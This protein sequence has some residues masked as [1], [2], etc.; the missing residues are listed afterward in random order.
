MSLS[1]IQKESR[2]S[3]ILALWTKVSS[4]TTLDDI[5]HAACRTAIELMQADRSTFVFFDE[6]LATG[7]IL[8]EHSRESMAHQLDSFKDDTVIP[9]ADVPEERRLLEEFKPIKVL[10]VR[11]LN[12]GIFK[13]NLVKRSVKSVLIMPVFSAKRLWGSFSLD[14]VENQRDFTADDEAL[15]EILSSQIAAA[16]SHFETQHKSSLSAKLDD[17][18]AAMQATRGHS[19]ARAKLVDKALE[20]CGW[21]A[22]A[23]YHYSRESAE[24]QYV[25]GNHQ[26]IPVSAFSTEKNRWMWGCVYGE[27]PYVIVEEA[28]TPHLFK[29]DDVLTHF[30]IAVAIK[31]SCFGELDSLLFLADDDLHRTF[32][33]LEIEYLYRFVRRAVSVFEKVDLWDSVW[34]KLNLEF[35]HL[36]GPGPTNE[37]ECNQLLHVFLTM[38][39]AQFGLKFNRALLYLLN[40]DRTQ[41][42][43]RMGVGHFSR[44]LWETD[45]AKGKR[46][47]T[48]QLEGWL[49]FAKEWISTPVEE[50]LRIEPP[51]DL[52]LSNRTSFEEVIEF[53]REVML[54]GDRVNDLPQRVRAMLSPTHPVLIAPL[55]TGA[56]VLGLIVIDKEFTGASNNRT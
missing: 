27:S 1:R 16:L 54:S 43:P 8:A 21:R 15:C 45:C 32:A 11:D 3:A 22:G 55:H 37:V 2:L 23:L 51:I 56:E 12:D 28:A 31:V 13:T 40:D 33:K 24:L 36:L 49:P 41:L 10:D 7:R 39:T 44:S 26:G 35:L 4:A 20:L 18:D 17:C 30:R 53:S 46:D 47:Q 34:E 25:S 48:N 29:V 14:S 5:C 38:V 52:N 9:L 50:R 6:S 19:E 42:L